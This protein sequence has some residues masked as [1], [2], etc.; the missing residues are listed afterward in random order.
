MMAWAQ[1]TLCKG[2]PR[3]VILVS[4][5][6]MKNLCTVFNTCFA[7]VH[8]LALNLK[9]CGF[10]PI[11]EKFVSEIQHLSSKCFYVELPLIWSYI[12]TGCM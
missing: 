6:A 10:N 8:L 7:N 3:C 1:Q 4:Y 2:S 12:D 11:L 9:V 5:Y